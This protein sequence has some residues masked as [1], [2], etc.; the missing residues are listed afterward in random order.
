[1]ALQGS[2]RI[3]YRQLECHLVRRISRTIAEDTDQDEPEPLRRGSSERHLK[4]RDVK[5][6]YVAI[7]IE[8]DH[9]AA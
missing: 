8:V 4:G 6:V 2:R 7:V 5:H 1:M 3:D 9:T